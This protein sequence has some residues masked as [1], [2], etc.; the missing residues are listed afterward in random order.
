[1][2]QTMTTP[3]DRILDAIAA[4]RTVAG[5]AS[6]AAIREDAGLIRSEFDATLTRLVIEQRVDLVPEDNQKTLTE[7]DYEAALY[8]GGEDKHLAQIAQ[9]TPTPTKAVH[10]ERAVSTERY[11]AIG[12]LGRDTSI[13]SPGG[14][15]GT[16]H[17][18]ALRSA[19]A[20]A[21]RYGIAIA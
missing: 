17:A 8:I 1:M 20:F 15:K 19:R 10:L 18:T 2:T 4:N 3:A 21:R 14:D 11:V 9:P 16:D 5:W 6:L 12:R 7:A 13:L